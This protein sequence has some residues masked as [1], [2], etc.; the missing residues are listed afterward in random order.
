M[1]ERGQLGRRR[2]IPTRAG[3]GPSA[4]I[5]DVVR[6]LR[7][8]LGAEGARSGAIGVGIAGQIDAR[9]GVLTS[10]NLGWQRVPL[11]AQL[12]AALHR[13]VEVTND[14]RAITF[15]EWQYGAARGARDAVCV[16]VG[17]GVGGGIIADGRLRTGATNTAGEV[18][19]MTL[20]A[21]GRPCHCRNVGCLE[22][23]VGGWAIAARA[24]EAAAEEPALGRPL[25]RRA[26]GLAEITAETVADAARAGDPLSGRIVAETE[27]YLAAGLVGVVNAIDP[28]VL[29]LG[30]GVIE[31]IPSLVPGVARRLRRSALAVVARRLSVARAALGGEAGVLGAAGMARLRLTEGG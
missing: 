15:G 10:P 4:I 1:T 11:R 14:L 29:V 22:A 26:G 16:F 5:A 13:P 9:G 24:R 17:T 27:R 18:G 28:E 30:G 7:T 25:V 6:T 19:H 23:Y 3:R 31:G 8:G 12:E 20:V 21:G 2:R